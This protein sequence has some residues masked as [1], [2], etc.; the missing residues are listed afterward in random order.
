MVKM[1]QQNM[2][3]IH[4]EKVKEISEELKERIMKYLTN[5]LYYDQFLKIME[6]NKQNRT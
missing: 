3:K 5:T 4:I 2:E 6:K 1:E